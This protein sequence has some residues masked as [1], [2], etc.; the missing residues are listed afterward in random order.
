M[1]KYSEVERA[2]MQPCQLGCLYEKKFEAYC[3][4]RSIPIYQPVQNQTL[5]DYVI[6][7]NSYYKTVN[8]KYRKFNSRD[9]CEL[10]LVSKAGGKLKQNY[11]RSLRL[12]Y[13]VLATDVYP[14][15]FFYLDLDVIRE[16]DKI[17][18][19][20]PSISLSRETILDYELS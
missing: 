20:Y 12:D 8:V 16:T 9:R 15:K 14:D 18:S 10:Q 19:D 3:I 7:H 13:I 4:E 1:N 17:L 11:L 2:V 6:I 5:E